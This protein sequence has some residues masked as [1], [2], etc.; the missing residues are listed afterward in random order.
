MHAPESRN[1]LIHNDIFEMC[2][3]GWVKSIVIIT[4]DIG[5]A[6]SV[7]AGYGVSATANYHLNS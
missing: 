6:K 4:E 7:F 1:P 3:I 2:A 5:P